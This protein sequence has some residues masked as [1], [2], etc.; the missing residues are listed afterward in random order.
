MSIFRDFVDEL[1]AAGVAIEGESALN[2]KVEH[3][4]NWPGEV[5]RLAVVGRKEGV[6]FIGSAVSQER[7][8]NILAR[9]PFSSDDTAA[10]IRNLAGNSQ[11]SALNDP[12]V[13]GHAAVVASADQAHMLELMDRVLESLPPYIAFDEYHKH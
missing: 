13:T 9:Y 7:L 4:E 5:A 10:L 1:K 3:A 11:V 8:A 12:A 2:E 6:S